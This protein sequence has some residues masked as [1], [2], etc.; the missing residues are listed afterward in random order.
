[1]IFI[2]PYIFMQNVLLYAS[3]YFYVESMFMIFYV[4]MQPCTSV[5][6]HALIR[7]SAPMDV[8]AAMCIHAPHGNIKKVTRRTYNIKGEYRADLRTSTL[9]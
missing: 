9:M 8:Y 3:I 5:Y 7:F 4:S 2:Y 1:M 6:F